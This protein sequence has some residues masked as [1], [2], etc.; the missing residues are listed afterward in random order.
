MQVS[1]FQT[2]F[3]KHDL[4]LLTKYA[5]GRRFLIE[6]GTGIST[7]Y[8]AEGI[9]QSDAIFY[10]VDINPT[11]EELRVKKGVNYLKGWAIRY[12]DFIKPKDPRFVKSNYRFIDSKIVFSDEKT[13]RSLMKGEV[14]LVRKI[15]KKHKDR[16]LDFYFSDCGEYCGYPEWLIIKEKIAEGGIFAAHDIYYPKSIKNFKV[17]EEIENSNEWIVLEKTNTKQGMFIAMKLPKDFQLMDNFSPLLLMYNGIR[18]DSVKREPAT[19]EWARNLGKGVLYDVGANVG[20]YS[21]MASKCNLE[22]KVYAFEPMYKN[23]FALMQNVI[24][25]NLFDR[26]VALN[27]AIADKDGFQKFNCHSLKMGS[28]LSSLGEPIDY[29]GDIFKP[30]FVHHVYAFSLDNLV[31]H[32]GLPAPTFVKIDVD[33]IE[34]VIVAGMYGQMRNKIKSIL[35]EG[36]ERQY[37]EFHPLIERA[38][39]ILAKVEEHPLTNNYIY[40]KK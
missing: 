37:N 27:C 39:F 20:A 15:L 35:I 29:K 9:D 30:E 25:N 33:S 40:N 32:H 17:V 11:K 24:V 3:D 19:V 34:A 28:A 31:M 38:G 8:I 26:I 14:D 13:A 4:E 18:K 6:T 5:K 23:Y 21:L 2:K 1:K 16:R 10:T 12:E 22:L 7:H 36:D